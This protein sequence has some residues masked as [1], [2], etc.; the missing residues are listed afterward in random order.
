MR[1]FTD[2]IS[3]IWKSAQA[4]LMLTLCR[5]FLLIKCSTIQINQKSY[6]TSDF[7]SVGSRNG[8]SGL[9][10]IIKDRRGLACTSSSGFRFLC[11]L[12]C[13]LIQCSWV[14]K[15]PRT[16]RSCILE[17]GLRKII[18]Q[19]YNPYTTYFARQYYL[20]E[21]LLSSINLPTVKQ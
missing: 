13:F 14:F 16:M 3:L 11:G 8:V 6:L 2:K 5:T 15:Q 1:S 4:I 18:Y 10:G 21:S 9:R 7:I 19:K 20:S 12:I 17:R